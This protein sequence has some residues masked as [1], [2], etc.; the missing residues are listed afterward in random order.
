[1]H[2]RDIRKAQN[3]PVEMYFNPL[4][5]M[6]N[7][8]W[9]VVLIYGS[10]VLIATTNSHLLM[11]YEK[12]SRKIKSVIYSIGNDHQILYLNQN[13]KYY[14]KNWF[15]N[16]IKM[17]KQSEEMQTLRAGCSKAEPK[18]LPRCRPPSRG[19]GTAKI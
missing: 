15:A 6:N 8:L 14:V 3:V 19:C 7:A 2:A 10:V 9:S 18:I 5:A 17:K 11:K 13:R 1:M 16:H 4:Q 12:F